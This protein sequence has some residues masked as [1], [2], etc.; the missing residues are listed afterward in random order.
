VGVLTE[1]TPTFIAPG[2]VVIHSER[3]HHVIG[4]ERHVGMAVADVGK[5]FLG[6]F[7]K[8]VVGGYF[9]GEGVDHLIKS[10]WRRYLKSDARKVLLALDRPEFWASK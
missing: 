3:D 1:G 7:R 6:H 5:G 10:S 2:L 4:L 8:I 9:D